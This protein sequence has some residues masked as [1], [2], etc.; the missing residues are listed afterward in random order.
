MS[1]PDTHAPSARHGLRQPTVV[2][3][4][5]VLSALLVVLLGLLVAAFAEVRDGTRRFSGSAVTI[6]N[7]A[8]VQRELLALGNAVERL[9][10]DPAALDEVELRVG[11]M[12]THWRATAVGLD[13]TD[14]LTAEVEAVGESIGTAITDVEAFLAAPDPADVPAIGERIRALDR[15]L[16]QV[17]AH[18]E[19]V[20]HGDLRTVLESRSGSALIILVVF[21]AVLAAGASLAMLGRRAL[22][23]ANRRAREELDSMEQRYGELVN[24]VREAIL[25]VD[26]DGRL[27]LV[28]PGW[29]RLTG[30]ERED[31][32]GRPLA[33]FVAGPQAELEWLVQAL[34]TRRPATD[35]AEV[36]LET[37]HDEPRWAE[38]SLRPSPDGGWVVTLVDVTK[39]VE[40]RRQLTHQALED[41]LTGLGNRPFLIDQLGRSLANNQR[42]G[43]RVGLIFIDLDRFKVVNDSLGHDVGDRLL[44]EVAIRIRAAVR[45]GDVACRLG[46]DEFV[47]LCEALPAAGPQAIA[48]M[49]EVARRILALL[50]EPILL[51][52]RELAIGASVGIAL[53][54]PGQRPEALLADADTA[55]YHAK[56]LGRGRVEVFDAELRASLQARLSVEH[57]LRRVTERDEL[58]LWMQPVFDL[59]SSRVVAFEGLLRW[60]HPTRGLLGPGA[61]LE[62]AEETGEIQAIGAWII[63][64]ACRRAV[65]WDQRGEPGPRVAV[66]VSPV[67]LA[68]GNLPELVTDALALTG[69]HPGRLEIEIT[70]SVYLLADDAVRAQLRALADLGVSIAMD[71]F[72]TGY[73]SLTSLRELPVNV[74]KLDRSFVAGLGV[75]AQDEAIIRSTIDLARALD[76]EV[77]GEGIEHA[78]QHRL[79]REMGCDRGQ[80]FLLSPPLPPGGERD[81]LGRREVVG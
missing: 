22:A 29:A 71:D 26:A 4:S 14:P 65:S 9:D 52:G 55:M 42:A 51:Q 67:Q 50:R 37:S 76:A 72:G 56:D 59:A 21:G 43:M 63:G 5:A 74:V 77:V 38:L 44:R 66:N 8:N 15:T 27:E 36:R 18:Q 70:E 16:K 46:G 1:H 48:V 68:S 80:G 40:A 75:E 7:L 30:C 6:T 47:V 35:T 73:S 13:P 31:S 54:E 62:V 60:C 58:E 81:F 28:N 53:A 79:L 57:A 49:D 45:A 20:Y 24:Q 23:R 32:L 25:R 12:A 11:L 3:L 19:V 10:R 64:E 78:R 2:V 69:L 34:A 39:R 33:D 17:Y 41:S 61:F